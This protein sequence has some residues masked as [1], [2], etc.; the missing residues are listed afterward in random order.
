MKNIKKLFKA[1]TVKYMTGKKTLGPNKIDN[2]S[3]F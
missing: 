2:M 1:M 3:L